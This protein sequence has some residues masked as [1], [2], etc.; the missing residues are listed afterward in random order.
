M[1]INR[2]ELSADDYLVGVVDVVELDVTE[3]GLCQVAGHFFASK[4]AACC[5]ELH[6]QTHKE[7]FSPRR[8]AFILVKEEVVDDYVASFRECFVGFFNK[9]LF[10]VI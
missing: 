9:H 3:P 7:V 10:V 1:S 4:L 5:C 2:S 6:V 8:L